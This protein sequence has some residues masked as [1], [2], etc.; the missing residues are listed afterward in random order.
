MRL[1]SLLDDSNVCVIDIP[2]EDLVNRYG[3]PI[4]VLNLI[5]ISF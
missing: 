2:F 4:I 1:L 5:K 3:N